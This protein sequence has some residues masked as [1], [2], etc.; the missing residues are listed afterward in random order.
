VGQT[1]NQGW[2]T[3]APLLSDYEGRERIS[4]AGERAIS[5]VGD[6]GET[7]MLNDPDVN[8]QLPIECRFLILI[9]GLVLSVRDRGPWRQEWLGEMWHWRREATAALSHA[10]WI[11][12]KRSL[13]AFYD[14]KCVLETGSSIQDRLF[15][16]R[17]SPI[18]L[19]LV[20]ACV[21]GVLAASTAGLSRSRALFHF[22]T[23]PE[24]DLLVT[25]SVPSPF[26]LVVEQTP[27]SQAASWMDGNQGLESIGR[28]KIERNIIEAN[29]QRVY[30]RV[31]LGDEA[32]LQL[33]GYSFPESTSG[34]SR[35]SCEVLLNAGFSPEFKNL[36]EVRI[37]GQPCSVGLLS[38]SGYIPVPDF[39]GFVPLDDSKRS[40][41]EFGI[42]AK[43][44]VGFSPRQVE[45]GLRAAVSMHPGWGNPSVDSLVE[46]LSAVVK[47]ILT[48]TLAAIAIA[49]L[50]CRVKSLWAFT[51]FL[52]R[53]SLLLSL[54]SALCLEL[55]VARSH[56]VETGGIAP[57]A[58]AIGWL[59]PLVSCGA[60]LRWLF[61]DHALR[62][63]VCQHS[64]A[65]PVWIGCVGKTVFEPFG[66]EWLCL[67]GHGRLL[68]S[69]S[70]ALSPEPVWLS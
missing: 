35:P 53:T 57:L 13:G 55:V 33:L 67:A 54:P 10:R 66:T 22:L 40:P 31:M 3:L 49:L 5:D 25:I 70:I 63:P 27:A 8:G 42:V 45:A 51:L 4:F 37:G 47:W 11:L 59:M 32:A 1:N 12:F 9:A 34:A 26:F 61:Q 38:R 52:V 69:N 20:L 36:K 15:D 39:D 43:R 30:R 58:S 48:V 23:N 41:Q 17:R 50:Y 21:W 68:Q 19:A 46:Q 2:R 18:A 62:C 28:W 29:G 65:E 14:A 7:L 6:A 16:L 44:R 24:N 60:L 64:L 56:L